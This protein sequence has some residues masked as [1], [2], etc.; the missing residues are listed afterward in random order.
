MTSSYKIKQENCVCRNWFDCSSNYTLGCLHSPV[1]Q[2]R[3]AEFHI[4][5]FC[6]VLAAYS[7]KCISCW[8]NDSNFFADLA[9]APPDELAVNRRA[10]FVVYWHNTAITVCESNGKW[11]HDGVTYVLYVG[12]YIRILFS[13]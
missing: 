13:F 2:W 1:V 7:L 10:D 6:R 5:C 3:K 9:S 11:I 4:V 8:Q 12:L